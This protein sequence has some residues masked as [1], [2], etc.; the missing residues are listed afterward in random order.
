MYI[1]KVDLID[2][3]VRFLLLLVL[4]QLTLQVQALNFSSIHHFIFSNFHLFTSLSDQLF[5]SS[6]YQLIIFSSSPAFHPSTS[7]YLILTSPLSPL[8]M[9]I[10]SVSYM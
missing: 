2:Q 5:I 4:H 6:S 10:K 8:K 7:H 1:I 9:I 3:V